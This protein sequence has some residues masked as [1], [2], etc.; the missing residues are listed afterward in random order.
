MILLS[1]RL[2]VVEIVFGQLQKETKARLS[3]DW[4]N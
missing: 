4:N 1:K 2:K 3:L